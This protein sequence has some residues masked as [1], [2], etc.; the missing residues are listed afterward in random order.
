PPPPRRRGVREP[1]DLVVDQAAQR[2]AQ[3]PRIAGRN[4]VAGQAVDDGVGEAAHGRSDDGNAAA[5]T[6]AP[7]AGGPPTVVPIPETPQAIASSGASS[8]CSCQGAATSTS[9]ERYQRGMSLAGTPPTSRT[10]SATVN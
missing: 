8:N 7:V 6:L 1:A 4:E 2:A 3:R 9:A 5:H 10:R